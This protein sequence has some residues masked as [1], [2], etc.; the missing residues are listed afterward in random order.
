MW[1]IIT[2]HSYGEPCTLP[3][4][5]LSSWNTVSGPFAPSGQSYVKWPNTKKIILWLWLSA[6]HSSSSQGLWLLYWVFFQSGFLLLV[7]LLEFCSYLFSSGF[8]AHAWR[9]AV[10]M[11]DLDSGLESEAWCSVP[12]FA[13]YWW[14]DF[15]Q[16]TYFS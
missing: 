12:S 5:N 8:R 2:L 14:L 3:F 15:S 4:M 16:L 9:D 6:A 13:S 10:T 1:I 11:V 7:L